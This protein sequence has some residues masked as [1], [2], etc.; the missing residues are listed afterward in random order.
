MRQ[1]SAVSELRLSAPGMPAG[2]AP[3]RRRTQ[4]R[5]ATMRR[6]L[7]P[8]QPASV[9]ADQASR[10]PAPCRLCPPRRRHAEEASR[11]L[12]DGPAPADQTVIGRDTVPVFPARALRT[13]IKHFGFERLWID[14]EPWGGVETGK[15]ASS[16]H[17][18]VTRMAVETRNVDRPAVFQEPLSP[19]YDAGGIRSAPDA[20]VI[21]RRPSFDRRL[22]LV[23]RILD[24]QWPG[25]RPI[26]KGSSGPCK[27][28]DVSSCFAY[29][30]DVALAVHITISQADLRAMQIARCGNLQRVRIDRQRRTQVAIQQQHAG[31]A[32]AGL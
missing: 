29:S 16:P 30:E 15:I 8:R 27:L 19:D 22:R 9:H 17:G 24:D 2:D 31:R 11:R 32:V 25:S 18:L 5:R 21:R 12:S 28:N 4:G 13:W 6:A 20:T 26:G 10:S 3:V 23:V 1:R 7:I 14:P